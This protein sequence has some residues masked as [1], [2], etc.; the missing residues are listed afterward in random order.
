MSDPLWQPLGDAL[1]TFVNARAAAEG[2]DAGRLVTQAIVVWEE[3]LLDE[4]GDSVRG[5]SYCVPTD[6]F[7][8]SGALGL[9]VAGQQYVQRDVIGLMADQGDE[10][11]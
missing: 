10:D 11:E 9:L 8:P 7:S 5:I 3:V 1:Q 6:N 4:D 2:E